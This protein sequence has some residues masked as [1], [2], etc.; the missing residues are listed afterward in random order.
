LLGSRAVSQSIPLCVK[1]AKVMDSDL[2]VRSPWRAAL[3]V[4]RSDGS[5]MCIAKEG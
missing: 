1:P 2:G 4:I 3:N 5:L